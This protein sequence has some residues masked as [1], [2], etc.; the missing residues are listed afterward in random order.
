MNALKVLFVINPKA[1]IKKK[2]NPVAFIQ[3]NFD[4]RVLYEIVVWEHKDDFGSIKKLLESNEYKIAV[5][6]GGDG[7]VNKVAA[8]I[9]HTSVALAILPM[10]SGNGLARSLGI[11]MNLKKALN[12]IANPMYAKIDSGIINGEY[13]FCTAG[14][15]FDAH[16]GMRFAQSTRRG[17]ASYIKIILNDFFTYRPQYYEVNIDGDKLSVTAFLITI[18]NSGQ[19]GNDFYIAPQALMNDGL[20]TLSILKPFSHY[21][22]PFLLQKILRKKA[23]TSSLIDYYSG[24]QITVTSENPAPFHF[25]GEPGSIASTFNI[26]IAPLSLN[27]VGKIDM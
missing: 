26:S 24:K 17:L 16:V 11:P 6:V 1:G 25:D 3:R 23:D 7:T 20:F 15:G 9:V 14:V 8:S 13:F 21:R 4:S 2:I 22:L 10:G 18:A 12:L 5:A 27:V 19:Y